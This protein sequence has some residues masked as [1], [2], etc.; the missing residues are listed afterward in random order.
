MDLEVRKTGKSEP[1]FIHIHG[2]PDGGQ[3][4]LEV[5]LN[6]DVPLEKLLG[7]FYMDGSGSMNE[8]GNYGRRGVL[9]GIGRQR[10][11]V[12]DAMRVAVPYIAEKDGNGRCRIAY[13]ATGSGKEIEIIGEL[14]AETAVSAAFPGPERF[15]RGT[16]LLP[17][18]RD[19]EAYVKAQIQQGEAV[20]SALAVIVTDGKLHDAEDVVAHTADLAGAI[21]AGQFPKTVY[22]LIGIGSDV[23]EAQL[24]RLMHQATP[25]GYPHREIFCYEMADT[26]EQLPALVSHLVN[27]N[28]PAFYGGATVEAGGQVVQTYEDMVP[29]VLAFA[30][31]L[32]AR[33]FTLRAG[34]RS[35]SQDFDLV[36]DD[37]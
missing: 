16:Y 36:E 25:P 15:G 19:F 6:V 21:A 28:T 37:D 26:L 20:D 3:L 14:S 13:W 31:P 17:A 34:E 18:L 23:D 22:T 27:Q 33:S 29:A 32:E 7:A 30:L 2:Q 1:L 35:F 5:T 24:N 11:P 8:S 9:F 4:A 12:E 10:N